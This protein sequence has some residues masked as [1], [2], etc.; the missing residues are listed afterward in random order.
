MADD[1][2]RTQLAPVPRNTSVK[3]GRE[4]RQNRRYLCEGLAEVSL[5]NRD[6]MFRGELLNL[7]LGGCFVATRLRLHLEARNP[8]LI[9]FNLR[10]HPYKTLAEVANVRH[11]VGIGFEFQHPTEG[12]AEDFK[13]L[14]GDYDAATPQE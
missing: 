9:R 7:S 13:I 12:V 6:T 2:L 10:N 8:V 4:R 14:V 5:L 1:P 11:G 3:T